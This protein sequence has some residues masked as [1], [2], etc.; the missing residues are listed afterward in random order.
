MSSAAIISV[1]DSAIAIAPEGDARARLEAARARLLDDA[2][3][4]LI[5][6]LR[7]V[8]KSSFVSALWGDADLLPTA[9]RDCTQTNTLVRVPGPGETDRAL[10]LAYLT[11]ERALDFATRSLAY[12]RLADF[13]RETLG[14]FG[15][16]LARG[17]PED[18]LRS[19][20][21]AVRKLFA[22]RKDLAVLN[23]P[24]TDLLDQVEEFLAFIDSPDFPPGKTVSVPWDLRREYIMGK[25]RP[26]G[27]T[28]DVGKLLALRQVDIIRAS[29]SWPGPAP[30]LF[31]TPWIPAFYNAR[32]AELIREQARA[33]D[34]LLILSLP[35]ILEPEE[36]VRM[37]LAER[38][39]LARRTFIVFNQVDTADTSAL[40]GRKGFE[41]DYRKNIETL[42][43]LGVREDR[44][45]MSCS[46]LPFLRCGHPD[47]DAQARIKRLED[48]LAEIHALASAHRRSPFTEKLLAACDPSNAGIEHVRRAVTAAC[49]PSAD[50]PKPGLFP[51]ISP[52]AGLLSDRER[53]ALK[54]IAA[55]DADDFPEDRRKALVDIQVRAS[56]LK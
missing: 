24:L 15:P 56:A 25:R 37:T 54:A 51:S 41:E 31:D 35:E 8:G 2:C 27:R 16:D 50:G 40:F 52:S 11:R 47:A 43:A 3:T 19:A 13:I 46:R 53:E 36:W 18:R 5:S 23:E 38:P 9:V 1:L 30:R 55:L 21:Q 22:E 28:L 20:A 45:L 14:P 10:R 4:V 44:F 42:A 33:I 34:V 49:L 26:D 7:S 39:E 12:L 32:R 29:A 48:A 17:A 6:G